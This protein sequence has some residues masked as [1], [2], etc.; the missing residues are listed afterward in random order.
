MVK[1]CNRTTK[2]GY[3]KE[4]LKGPHFM[5]GLFILIPNFSAFLS[6]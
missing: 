6:G 5:E 1:K 3:L 4:T 2:R